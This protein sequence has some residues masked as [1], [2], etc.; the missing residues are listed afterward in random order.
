MSFKSLEKLTRLQIFAVGGC[1][2]EGVLLVGGN[3]HT[4]AE[5]GVELQKRAELQK[6]MGNAVVKA[7]GCHQLAV[8]F[9]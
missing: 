8:D 6:K 5:L 1:G 4:A 9:K 2:D 7:C 3:V